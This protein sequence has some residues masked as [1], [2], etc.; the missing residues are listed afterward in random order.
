M[1]AGGSYGQT[2]WGAQWL[3]ALSQTDY[4]NRLPHVQVHRL[5]TRTTFEERINDMIK[6]KRDLADLTVGTGEKWI[7]I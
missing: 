6:S 7:G 4:D 5:I 3:N 1:T 2:W